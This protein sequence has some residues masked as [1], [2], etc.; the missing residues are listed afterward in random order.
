MLTHEDKIV[1]KLACKSLR[2]LLQILKEKIT[3]GYRRNLIHL[4]VC[5]IAEDYKYSTFDERMETF[6]FIMT[7]LEYS[8]S[9]F[10]II[11]S[12]GVISLSKFNDEYFKKGSIEFLRHLSIARP[13]QCSQVGGLKVLI[14]NLL[15]SNM[16][17]YSDYIFHTVVY[18]L[19]SNQHRVYFKKFTELYRIF[20]IFTKSEY[21][22]NPKDR[23]KE[24][25][26]SNED[27]NKL[28]V[29][30][31]LSKNIIIKLLK[32][33]PGYYLIFG[34]KMAMGSII[35][36]LNSDTCYFIKK[37]ILEML[38]E[39][40]DLFELGNID[41]FH[42]ILHKHDFYI[43]KIYFAY[44][45][46]GLK[47]VYL[48]KTLAVFIEREK[49]HLCQLAKQIRLKFLLLY[50]KLSSV[51]IL[52]PS[53]NNETNMS[54]LTL[55]SNLNDI[56]SK[57]DSKSIYVDNLLSESDLN[58]NV[59][60]NDKNSLRSSELKYLESGVQ[61]LLSNKS[62]K[63]PTMTQKNEELIQTNIKTM[64]LLD[65]KFQYFNQ[66]NVLTNEQIESKD[67]SDAIILA[68]DILTFSDSSRKYSNE[69]TVEMAK[70][71][72]FD[73]ID[74]NSF[75][76]LI[77]SSNI[78]AKDPTDWDWKKIDEILDIV[79]YKQ[80]MSKICFLL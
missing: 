75:S 59:L 3:E 33:W 79:D 65:E 63:A 30:L 74:E 38:K 2:F 78:N 53:S 60:N 13:D 20:S 68:K 41:N 22:I 31:D 25:I 67:Y 80:E 16:I 42:C 1:R 58:E 32:T 19:N 72:L 6:K 51:D 18:L 40:L 34:N 62:T 4:I 57:T 76:I 5:K 54:N 11:L 49:N 64:D 24:N 10:P 66:K 45:I 14:S 39:I 55:S 27:K 26:M 35:Q 48:Y 36:S 69:Y 21:S 17:D 47:S 61:N 9:N 46:Q 43:N 28:D 50:S 23:D 73:L 44:I 70:K 12:H 8:P 71:E 15:D 29:Q 52:L 7:W 56:L 37:A 77:K